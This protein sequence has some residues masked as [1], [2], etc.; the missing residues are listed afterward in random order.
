MS[1]KTNV[2]R[3]LNT[4]T[5]WVLLNKKKNPGI[6]ASKGNNNMYIILASNL[7][8]PPDIQESLNALPYSSAKKNPD[9]SWEITI[10]IETT[11]GGYDDNK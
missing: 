1:D 4:I 6:T 7:E 3:N 2:K 10:P 5:T 11:R 9:G 8:I